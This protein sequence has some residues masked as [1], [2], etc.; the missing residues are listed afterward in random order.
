MSLIVARRLGLVAAVAIAVGACSPQSSVAAGAAADTQPAPIAAASQPASS[1]QPVGTLNGRV[2]PDFATGLFSH[3]VEKIRKQAPGVNIEWLA[4]RENMLL[5]VADGH[6]D[7]AVSP[8]AIRRPDGVGDRR[9]LETRGSSVTCVSYTSLATS[10]ECSITKF[11][12]VRKYFPCRRICVLIS[13][14]RK[15]LATIGARVAW[16]TSLRHDPPS[17]SSDGTEP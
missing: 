9:C 12:A 4:R 17:S 8:A 15:S 7:L 10:F 13:T 14:T 5:D 6:I 3:L 11:G 1:P 16:R 2:L